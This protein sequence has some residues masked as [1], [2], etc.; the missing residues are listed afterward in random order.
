MQFIQQIYDTDSAVRDAYLEMQRLPFVGNGSQQIR[1]QSH[2]WTKDEEKIAT[3]IKS[4]DG[5][6]RMK[7]FSGGSCLFPW[8][9]TYRAIKTFSKDIL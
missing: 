6:Y 8:Y 4:A 9:S 7:S 2:K 3:E 1:K 5:S